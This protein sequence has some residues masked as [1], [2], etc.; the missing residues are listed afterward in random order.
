MEP[1]RGSLEI[2][3][4]L[5]PSVARSVAP[6]L[7]FSSLPG[8]TAK[9]PSPSPAAIRFPGQNR[10]PAA[11]ARR[12][13]ESGARGQGA[14]QNP[15]AF[16]NCMCSRHSQNR[17]STSAARPRRPRCTGIFAQTMQISPGKCG[18]PSTRRCPSSCATEPVN[19][20]ETHRLP[21]LARIG[22]HPPDHR[23]VDPRGIRRRS[24]GRLAID[25]SL[26]IL[27]VSA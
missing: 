6:R 4:F 8:A 11:T 16:D 15:A 17:S 12:P 23:R 9:S 14:R 19:K 27:V 25:E 20:F 26:G 7:L 1:P 5:T 21:S 18:K 2:F 24:D 22:G 10:A 13:G 3:R